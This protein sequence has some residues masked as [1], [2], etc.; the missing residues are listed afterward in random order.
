MEKGTYSFRSSSPIE[1]QNGEK[2][3]PCSRCRLYRS[4]RAIRSV[5][6]C[7]MT[8]L[9][10]PG[11]AR[12]PQACRVFL[13]HVSES[14]SKSR[15]YVASHCSLWLSPRT[16]SCEVQPPLYVNVKSVQSRSKRSVKE[17]SFP[18][19]E[20]FYFEQRRG[21]AEE[22]MS[23]GRVWATLSQ[24]A[25]AQRTFCAVLLLATSSAALV[26]SEHFFISLPTVWVVSGRQVSCSSCFRGLS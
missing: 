24:P 23:L 8:A 10:R 17:Q 14:G 19:H 9:G 3:L 16:S 5:Q 15:C 6:D 7:S 22:T 11:S 20:C 25:T 12:S 4:L 13:T 2:Y 18:D 1:C 26:E 21:G